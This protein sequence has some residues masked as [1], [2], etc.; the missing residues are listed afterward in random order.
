MIAISSSVIYLRRFLRQSLT[1]LRFYSPSNLTTSITIEIIQYLLL[2]IRLNM[3]ADSWKYRRL[4]T[5]NVR[6]R[7]D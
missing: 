1:E 3:I 4:Q 2:H 6:I 7:N 5:K